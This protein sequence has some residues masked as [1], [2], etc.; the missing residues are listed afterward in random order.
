M[1]IAR[2]FTA[3]AFLAGTIAMNASAQTVTEGRAAGEPVSFASL[4]GWMQDDQLAALRT[5][6][7]SCSGPHPSVVAAAL[8]FAEQTRDA[9][10]PRH[11]PALEPACKALIEAGG[12][13]RFDGE[14]A[15][16]FFETWFEPVPVV[17]PG[18][19]PGH[20]TA[21]YEPELDG[22]LAPDPN[23][24]APL[25]ARPVDLVPVGP[26]KLPSGLPEGLTAARR[27]PAGLEP[28]PERAA[29][30]DPQ[31][32]NGLVPLVW[33][34]NEVD[35]YFVHI[36]GSVRVRVADG[37]TMRLGYA[38]KNGHP[39]RSAGRAMIER[40]LVPEAGM[41]AEAM[42]AWLKAH[43]DLASDILAVNPSY[44][45]FQVIEGLADE[46]G[47]IGAEGVAL[48]PGRSLAVDPRHIGYGAP[49]FITAD[50]PTGTAMR[51]EPFRRL[52]IAQDTGS[53]IRGPARG[54]LFWGTGA[55]AGEIAGR[56]SHPATFHVLRPR[57]QPAQ[58]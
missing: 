45:F 29:L 34:R 8:A 20:V 19:A 31:G 54:D 41:T 2:R 12:A 37:S 42:K 26:A 38:G 22:A 33:L 46:L 25:Y 32:R 27:T 53:A 4:D 24:P 23:H 3:M 57:S 7:R 56:I 13:S 17:L 36:Q 14:S 52:M 18:N 49:V 51:T 5:F 48:T 47:P 11:D 16:R 50:L 21:Y 58:R 55:Q 6:E 43:P 44:V 10:V 15:R 30:S 9:A 39:Y 35:A 40:G 28:Y 1:H